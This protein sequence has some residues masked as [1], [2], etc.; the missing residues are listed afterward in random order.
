MQQ[1]RR[2]IDTIAPDRRL[3]DDPGRNRDRQGTGGA[4]PPR[5]EPRVP[6]APSSRSTAARCPKTWSRASS[7]AIARAPSPAPTPTARGSSRSPT[8][9][10]SSSTK[11]ASSTRASRSSSCGSSNPVRFARS[12]RTSPSGSMSGCCARPIA[13]FARWWPTSCSAKISSSASI[14]SR[15]TCRRSA[16]AKPTSVPWPTT[17]C[18]V[19]QPGAA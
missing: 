13:I 9:A 11:S 7:S 19:M 6:I 15:S 14:R 10:R 4:Q 3:G 1:V 12:A 16:S 2:L 18:C 8:A 5:Q 17:C